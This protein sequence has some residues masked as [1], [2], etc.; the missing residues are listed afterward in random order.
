M[1]RIAYFL[2][3]DGLSLLT[4]RNYTAELRHLAL[5]GF[6]TGSVEG[7]IASVVAAKTFAAPGLLTSVIFAIPIVVNVFNLAWGSLIRGHR[8]IRTYACLAAA[9]LVLICSIAMT[10][11]GQPWS[12]W[13]F[14]AQIAG[15]HFFLS[16]M[17]TLR[18]TMWRA[19]YSRI[20]RAQVAGRLQMLN[21]L[22]SLLSMA[23]LSKLFDL[24]PNYYRLVYPLIVVLGALSLLP[25]RRMRVRGER[26]EVRRFRAHEARLQNGA[27]AISRVWNGLKEAAEIMRTDQRFAGYMRA[28]ILLGSANFF[29]DPV[30]VAILARR[31]GFSYWSSTF[32]IYLLPTLVVLISI[33]FWSKLFD[34]VG[35]LR[36]RV[37]NSLVWASSYAGLIIAMAML[38]VD[39]R[40]FFIAAISVLVVARV[41]NGLARGG[42]DLA[43]NIG[44]LHFANERQTELYMGI[45]LGLTGLRGATMPILGWIANYYLQ[46]GSFMISLSLALS[47][48]VL[49]RRMALAERAAAAPAAAAAVTPAVA[50]VG[51]AITSGSRPV[52]PI[53]SV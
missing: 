36:F 43:W 47:S 35:V 3:T 7:T 10:P 22:L 24:N 32:L 12:A 5:W 19:N 16:G 14:A 37:S 9:A 41:F 25:L 39:G 23:L 33:K 21:V 1:R 20:Y 28:M 46:W 15:T 48:F 45:H 49:F 2:H 34:R 52:N 38:N 30:L 26:A 6:V 11:R 50:P 42:G 31:E 8:R 18:T 53:K 17:L 4:R 44:H 27:G 13:L 40:G 51:P 29:T